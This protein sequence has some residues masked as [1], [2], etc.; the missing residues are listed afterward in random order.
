[1][2]ALLAQHPLVPAHLL[3][4]EILE[5]AA[6]QDVAHMREVMQACQ[7]LG[8]QFALD[9]FIRIS[10]LSYL[11]QLPAETIKIDRTFVD[12]LLTDADDRTLVSAIVGLS[13]GVLA[14]GD[15]RRCGDGGA[16]QQTFG[17]G[18]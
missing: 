9:D 16:G 5:S 4:L 18:L 1:M 10:S 11:K 6:L 17:P 15:C 13:R 8:V 7:A 12:G 3:E 14:V 2:R